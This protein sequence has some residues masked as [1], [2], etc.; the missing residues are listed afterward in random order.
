MASPKFTKDQIKKIGLSVLLMGFLIYAYNAFLVG[1]LGVRDRQ[2]TAVLKDIDAK[3]GSAGSRMKRLK[4]LE[5]QSRS[6]TETVAVVNSLIPEGEPIAWFP[7]RMRAFFERQGIKDVAV[8]LDRKEKASEPELA[9]AGYNN[10][11][12]TL[13][14]PAVAYTPLGI[15]LAGLENEE[16]LLEVQRLQISTQPTMP[17]QQRVS[18]GVITLMR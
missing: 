17:E 6:A 18:L 8:K 9:V 12:W 10:F 16:Q 2:N 13:E 4:A 5:D 1:P 15:A 3:I 7:P 14:A 11:V